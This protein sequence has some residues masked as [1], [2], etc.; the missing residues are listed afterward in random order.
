MQLY[1][2]KHQIVYGDEGV[3]ILDFLWNCMSS[4]TRLFKE[5]YEF[6]YNTVYSA[7]RVKY[8]IVYGAV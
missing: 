2:F 3:K 8:Y 7:V 4:N 1:E 5:L 6:N